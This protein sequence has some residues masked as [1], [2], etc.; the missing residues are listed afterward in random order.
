[1]V[2][3]GV[4]QLNKRH[5]C[6]IQDKCVDLKE[7]GGNTSGQS[8]SPSSKNQA[9]SK[10][11]VQQHQ[12]RLRE[13]TVIALLRTLPGQEQHKNGGPL[14]A[15]SRLSWEETTIEAFGNGTCCWMLTSL[16]GK[17]KS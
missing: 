16:D 14:A 9:E 13:R 11:Q 6:R 1:M 17:L 12:C 10:P 4:G 5:R 8:P 7:I 15:E 2:T 3:S